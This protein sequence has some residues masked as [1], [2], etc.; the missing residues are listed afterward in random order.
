MGFKDFAHNPPSPPRLELLR[1][2]FVLGT[3]VWSL[4]LYPP[5]GT[6]SFCVFSPCPLCHTNLAVM[7]LVPQHVVSVVF[8]KLYNQ[9]KYPK[10]VDCFERSERCIWCMCKRSHIMVHLHWRRRYGT[11]SGFDSKLDATLYYA[12]HFTLLRLGSLLPIS[13]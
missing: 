4:S 5:Q 2:D 10:K 13:V 11:D 6:V 3:G 8:S 1:E 12:E 9:A 7:K